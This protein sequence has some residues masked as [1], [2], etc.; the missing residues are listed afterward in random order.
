MS[1]LARSRTRRRR[2][3]LLRE[4]GARGGAKLAPVEL[5]FDL[6]FAFAITQLAQTL[7]GRLDAVG[8][9][10][11]AVLFLAVWWVW[12]CSTFATHWLDPERSAVRLMLFVLMGV[13]LLMSWALPQAFG[14]DGLLFA[15]CCVALQLGGTLFLLWALG[16]DHEQ[17]T[18]HFRRMTVWFSVSA[19]L[20]IAGARAE[21]DD[22]LL[23]WASAI[24]IEYAAV[25]IGYAVPGLGRSPSRHWAIEGEH[26][27]ERCALFVT[28]A[29]GVAILATG[30]SAAEMTATPASVAAFAVAFI[31]S[32]ALWWIHAH[33]GSGRTA[34]PN[35]HA[36]PGRAARRSMAYVHLPIV[37][38]IV[39]WA[40][41]G[42]LLLKQPSGP[43]DLPLL[44][45]MLAG[46]TLFLLGNLW[47]KTLISHR[48]PLSHLVGFALLAAIAIV[49]PNLEPLGVGAAVAGALVIVAGWQTLSKRRTPPVSLPTEADR[50]SS[51]PAKM[52]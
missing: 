11:T 51:L 4:P 35:A 41:A 34:P 18:R 16:N 25:W 48:T 28:I 30:S 38:G 36:G 9:I 29:L 2:P 8:A 10:E 3:S 27:A 21:L 26:L 22:R 46:P 49:S 23:F 42:A 47:L 37:G 24:A 12:I 7:L 6:V 13:G 31:G 52:W 20:W 14:T 33:P 19:L 43:V 50:R 1:G 15:G 5:L 32:A 40:V 44:V 45:P 17:L 39:I